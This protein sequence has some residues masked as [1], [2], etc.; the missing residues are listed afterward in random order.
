MRRGPDLPHPNATPRC[1][2]WRRMQRRWRPSSRDWIAV[3]ARQR[4]TPKPW[5]P[6]KESSR[7]TENVKE[8][9]RH[10]SERE[11]EHAEALAA[12]EN[13]RKALEGAATYVQGERDAARRVLEEVVPSDRPP[14]KHRVASTLLVGLRR[15][16]AARF[17]STRRMCSSIPSVSAS[18]TLVAR[19]PWAPSCW[20]RS[21]AS[22]SSPRLFAAA[23]RPRPSPG[24]QSAC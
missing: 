13:S 21:I 20:R 1:P 18:L 7:S 4:R 3:S 10:L 24:P 15:L 2:R 8:R 17:R 23:R 11:A 22:N 9:E 16:R 5:P 19:A 14:E 6:A 12:L